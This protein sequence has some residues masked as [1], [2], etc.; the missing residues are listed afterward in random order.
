M[1]A[2][3]LGVGVVLWPSW[4]LPSLQVPLQGLFPGVWPEVEDGQKLSG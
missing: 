3:D 4:G 1:N 2:W